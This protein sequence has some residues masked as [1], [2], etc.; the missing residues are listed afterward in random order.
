M[1]GLVVL[2]TTCLVAFLGGHEYFQ[3]LS[4][5]Q[6]LR[7]E[8][9]EINEDIEHVIITGGSRTV[10]VNIPRGFTLNFKSNKLVTS[11]V[12]IPENGYD[13]EVVGPKIGFG[14]HSLRI[15]IENGTVKVSEID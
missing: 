15:F 13:M 4:A 2:A 3:N 11:E 14:K 12:S 7:N 1:L 5:S 10:E 9:Y 6:R 8:A